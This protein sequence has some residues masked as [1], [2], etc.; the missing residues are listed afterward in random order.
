MLSI[1]K[2]LSLLLAAILSTSVFAACSSGS[3]TVSEPTSDVELSVLL[4]AALAGYDKSV[5][6]EG[7]SFLGGTAEGSDNYLDEATAGLY[8]AGEYGAEV[9]GLE[10][11]KDYVFRFPVGYRVF[12]IDMIHVSDS[13]SVSGA[14]ALLQ[15]RLNC[16]NNGNIE[17]YTPSEVPYL[18]AAEVYSTGNY[19]FLLAT[20]DNSIARAIIKN[21]L[22]NPQTTAASAPASEETAQPD[23]SANTGETVS[24]TKSAVT[25]PAQT[26]SVQARSDTKS[27]QPVITLSMNN[28]NRKMLIGGKCAVGATIYIRGGLKDMTY[29]T[30]DGNFLGSVDLPA[31]GTVTLTITQNEPGKDESDPITITAKAMTDVTLSETK[32]AYHEIIGN[33]YHNYVVDEVADYTGTNLY[34]DSQKTSVSNKIEKNVAYLKSLNPGAEIIYL[35]VPTQMH[36]YPESVPEQYIQYTA[37]SRTAQFTKLARDAGAIV[38]DLYDAFYKLRDGEYNLF[39]YTDTHWSYFGAYIGYREL[40]NYISIKWPDAAPRAESEYG[41]YNKEV[42]CGDLGEHLMISNPL[43]KETTTFYNPKFNI[44]VN[45]D[46]Y[47]NNS[48]ELYHTNTQDQQTIT[49]TRKGLNL[50]KAMIIRDSY[51][52]AAFGIF[53]DAFSEVYWRAMWDYT[54][55][56][57]AISKAKPDYIIYLVT[58]RN[59]KSIVE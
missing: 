37:D 12:E 20:T 57:D 21:M 59:I 55:S 24:D 17:E 7:R 30:R 54:F 1:K 29:G 49:N 32:G 6:P 15:A 2:L 48:V 22:E 33:N 35:L 45:P 4:D 34:T 5:V 38:I 25:E 8:F 19:V 14:E 58:E 31:N 42:D 51:G 50:P 44:V 43:L 41:F 10:D 11:I 26:A 18:E 23:S 13:S 53:S 36:L 46:I 28:E 47:K 9:K 52:T 27:A 3:K 16:K 56:K 40:M 39:H